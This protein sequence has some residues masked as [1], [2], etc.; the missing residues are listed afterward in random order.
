MIII[1]SEKK[2]HS[3]DNGAD[4]NQIELTLRSRL[5]ILEW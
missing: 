2:N 3:F 5:E 1:R 4:K